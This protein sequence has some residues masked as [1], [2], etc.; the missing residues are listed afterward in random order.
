MDVFRRA[1]IYVAIS[2]LV[3]GLAWLAAP[4]PV[5]AECTIMDEWPAFRDGAA[6][7][8]RIVVGEV[9]QSYSYDSADNAVEFH[10]A[11]TD[12]LRGPM[13]GG[14]DFRGGT[15]TEPPPT[16]CPRD[17]ILRVRVGDILAIA[18]D[19]A[20]DSPTSVRA[21]AWVKGRPHRF[22]MR[23]AEVL[24]LREARAVAA[25]PPTDTV[26]ISPTSRSPHLPIL[27]LVVGAIAGW[28]IFRRTGVSG[29]SLQ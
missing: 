13:T 24:S 3:L 10:V 22:L 19:G 4:L 25:M 15:Q 28:F 7:A 16:E 17:S 26:S 21:V 5:L 6:T 8:S 2:V 1:P 18:F 9:D 14:L 27:P 29:S 12:V 23:G 20:S 11:V